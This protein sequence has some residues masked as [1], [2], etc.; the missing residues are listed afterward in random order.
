VPGVS[1]AILQTMGLIFMIATPGPSYTRWLTTRPVWY[2]GAL[3]VWCVPVDM[4]H[5]EQERVEDLL[6]S[7]DN[8]LRFTSAASWL[9]QRPEF[10]SALGKNEE[11]AEHWLCQCS[12]SSAAI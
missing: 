6:L 12:A 2:Q 10:E 1:S 8:M 9:L 5:V 11:H 7:E 4:R 3:V